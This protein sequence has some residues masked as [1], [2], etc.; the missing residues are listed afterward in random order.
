MEPYYL[1]K[2]T[3]ENSIWFWVYPV[4]LSLKIKARFTVT[5]MKHKFYPGSFTCMNPPRELSIA[6]SWRVFW[7]GGEP[8]TM[9]EH[10]HV[11]ISTKLLE[12]KDLIATPPEFLCVCVC[13]LFSHSKLK[14]TSVTNFIIKS[15]YPF[16]REVLGTTQMLIYPRYW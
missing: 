13:D 14:T 3:C 10:F 7:W 9:K 12:R 2:L 4:L 11:S 6:K 16:Y 5:L 8:L 15:V 1:G